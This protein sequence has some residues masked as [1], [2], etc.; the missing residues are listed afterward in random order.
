MVRHLEEVVMAKVGEAEVSAKGFAAPVVDDAHTPNTRASRL[1]V[2]VENKDSETVTKNLGITSFKEVGPIWRARVGVSV[3]PLLVKDRVNEKLFG[4]VDEKAAGAHAKVDAAPMPKP[5]KDA[6]H[7]GIDASAAASKEKISGRTDDLSLEKMV[8]RATVYVG[9]G[10]SDKVYVDA[11]AGKRVPDVGAETNEFDQSNQESMRPVNNPVQRGVT[12]SATGVVNVGANIIVGDHKQVRID[13]AGYHERPPVIDGQRNIGQVVMMSDGD[14][15]K[16]DQ[17]HKLNSA[18]LRVMYKQPGLTAYATGA[19]VDGQPAGQ[20]GVE[21]KP[22]EKITLSVDATK[23]KRDWAL[24]EGI[25]A[26][27]SYRSDPIKLGPITIPPITTYGGVEHVNGMPSPTESVKTDG[28][29][30][31]TAGVAGVHT[32]IPIVDG[33][34]IQA[35]LGVSAE[36]QHRFKSSGFAPGADKDTGYFVGAQI[37]MG[38]K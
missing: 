8:Q 6:Y 5:Y 2:T 10:V 27:G 17:V 1:D 33:K 14:Y 18:A 7:A 4:V 34:H 26:I 16:E 29:V 38:L 12:T 37:E 25:S 11:E 20:V 23:G 31:Y 19:L 15:E 36:V 30:N 9:S 21:I 28:T 3:V 32:T 35:K 24:K 22:T 13:A